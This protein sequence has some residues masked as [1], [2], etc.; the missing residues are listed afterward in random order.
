MKRCDKPDA[1]GTQ[2]V[3]F[4]YK[5]IKHKTCKISL[6]SF[7][8]GGISSPPSTQN[9]NVDFCSCNFNTHFEAHM[10]LLQG[11]SSKAN[12]AIEKK[13]LH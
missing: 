9:L 6:K 12:S 5:R 13:V 10:N 4:N 11:I 1:H 3:V 2:V 8:F 7:C